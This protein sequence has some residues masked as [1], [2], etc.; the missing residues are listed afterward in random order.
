MPAFRS[1]YVA[2]VGLPNAGKST[3]LNALL[4][5]KLSITSARPQTTRHR[6]LG[7]LSTEQM[8]AIL[9]DTPGL[10]QPA[11]ALHRHLMDALQKAV[12]DADVLLILLDAAQPPDQCKQL[13]DAL[14]KPGGPIVVAINKVD[15]AG[16]PAAETLRTTASS[17]WPQASFVLISA[18]KQENLPQL[19]ELLQTCLPEHPPYFPTDQLTDRTERFRASEVIR[20]VI[21]NQFQQ[22]IP[23]SSEV[24][25]TD[26]TEQDHQV[27]ICADIWVERESQKA[28]VLGRGGSAIRRLGTTARQMLAEM[29]GKNVVLLLTVKV[30]ENW[31]RQEN[32]LKKLGYSS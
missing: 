8:Q 4:G 22:E 17:F 12:E 10:I 21:F 15:I 19:L 26:W 29:L 18:L 1:G 32:L 27:R 3:L 7:I 31:R 30:K 16:K 24:I 6:V 2:I 14:G 25:V 13:A 5:E 11:Y 9:V 28:I 20:E 23:Y